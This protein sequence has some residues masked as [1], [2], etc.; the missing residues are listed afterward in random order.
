MG[1][2][3]L[4]VCLRLQIVFVPVIED[5]DMFRKYPLLLN[6]YETQQC[7][8]LALTVTQRVELPEVCQ[9]IICGLS[10]A[11]IGRT[12]R[13]LNFV[14]SDNRSHSFVFFL[15]LRSLRLR[16]DRLVQLAMRSYRWPMSL[17]AVRDGHQVSPVHAG[18]VPFLA[19]GLH[20]VQLPQYGRAE[21]LVQR[22]QRRVLLPAEHLRTGLQRVLAGLLELPFVSTLRVQRAQ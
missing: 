15:S 18:H 4:V 20:E 3:E 14:V 1:W 16:P 11:T 21:Q 9:R 10:A 2:F 19:G 5:I 12:L 6:D 22:G 13:K 8:Q 7:K 17:Q